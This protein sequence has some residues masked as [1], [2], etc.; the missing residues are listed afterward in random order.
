MHVNPLS[1]IYYKYFIYFWIVLMVL[2]LSCFFFI[3]MVKFI[4]IF[5]VVYRFL[6]IVKK[7]YPN[8]NSRGIHD[9]PRPCVD[10][11]LCIDCS[12]I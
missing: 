4:G 1:D 6:V 12:C 7:T 11:I 9:I 5:F 2:F 10:S 8:P 3:Y